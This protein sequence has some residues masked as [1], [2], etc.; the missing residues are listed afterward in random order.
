MCMFSYK[1]WS[2][3]TWT[4]RNRRKN[5]SKK[6]M[7]TV[8]KNQWWCWWWWWRSLK[9]NWFDFASRSPSVDLQIH[10]SCWPVQ[11]PFIGWWWWLREIFDDDRRMM[12][13][14]KNRQYS[15]FGK[16]LQ[17]SLTFW[18]QQLLIGFFC[19]RFSVL[20]LLLLY[21]MKS[22]FFCQFSFCCFARTE[23]PWPS[24]FDN[25]SLNT[26]SK[27]QERCKMNNSLNCFWHCGALQQR[28]RL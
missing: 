3:Q 21:L 18:H 17:R 7:M 20:T 1:Y 10:L 24:A 25:V 13:K 16:F 9:N 8:I 12:T 26:A 4:K 23:I 2:W 28:P 15:S 19:D 5:G 6:V 22:S 27:S 14:L 11:M